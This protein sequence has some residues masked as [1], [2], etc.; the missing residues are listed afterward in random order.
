[1]SER[2]GVWLRPDAPVVDMRAGVEDGQGALAEQG[3]DAAGTGFAQLL[4]F[5]LR[6]RFET[7][8][9]ADGGID[10]LALRH[11]YSLKA[12]PPGDE[13]PVA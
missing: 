13:Q 7:A 12:Q 3:I 10:D 2:G 5:T 9:G 11:S 8:L 6:Q 4:D 1:M